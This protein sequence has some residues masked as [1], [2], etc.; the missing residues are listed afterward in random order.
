MEGFNSENNNITIKNDPM[1]GFRT[2]IQ[3]CFMITFNKLILFQQFHDQL[4]FNIRHVTTARINTG[5][6]TLPIP[7]QINKYIYIYHI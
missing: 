2:M 3:N 7:N 5:S 4:V 1:R 6:L